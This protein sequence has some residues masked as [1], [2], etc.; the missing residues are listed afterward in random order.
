MEDV[1]LV[2]DPGR[3]PEASPTQDSSSAR[4]SIRRVSGC[5]AESSKV[6]ASASVSPPIEL[7]RF[8]TPSCRI[9]TDTSSAAVASAHQSPSPTPIT[10]AMVA[11]AVD[12]SALLMSASANSTLSCSVSESASFLYPRNTGPMLVTTITATISQPDQ[13][14]WP[15]RTVSPIGGLSTVTRVLTES[16]AR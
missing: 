15:K 8:F 1:P 5:G 12:Q 16:I 7:R 9:E 10:P 11:T 3:G 14:A 6:R 13:I 2:A 4:S